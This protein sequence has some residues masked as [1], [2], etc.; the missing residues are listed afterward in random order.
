MINNLRKLHYFS[1]IFT[2]AFFVLY[3]LSM[4]NKANNSNSEFLEG[5]PPDV[6]DLLEE[7]NEA[8]KQRK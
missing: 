1:H 7:N 4:H 5:L 8:T 3:L 2:I 6:A